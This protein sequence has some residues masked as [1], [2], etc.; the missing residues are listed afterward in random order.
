MPRRL[1]ATAISRHLAGAH[2][3]STWVDGEWTA[4]FR[5]ASAGRS[6]VVVWF[7]C[8][9]RQASELE[10]VA[11]RRYGATLRSLGYRVEVADRP[12]LDG[13]TGRRKLYVTRGDGDA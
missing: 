6:T 5:A 4:G 7:E 10:P 2:T 1:V 9:P 13:Q 11:L 8:P 3:R 12:M